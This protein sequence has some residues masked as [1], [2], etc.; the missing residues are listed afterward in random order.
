LLKI[1]KLYIDE[2][3]KRMRVMA[4]AVKQRNWTLLE[5]EAHQLK[6]SSGSIGTTR[7]QQK[8]L[9]I[10]LAARAEDRAEAERHSSDLLPLCQQSILGLK[11]FVEEREDDTTTAL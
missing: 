4:E 1:I 5:S 10:E 3:E 2:T 11:Q 7:L 9:A 8:A 6:S